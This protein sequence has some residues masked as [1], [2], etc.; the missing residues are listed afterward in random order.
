MPEFRSILVLNQDNIGD[1][2]CTTPLIRRLRDA[3]PA[4]RIDALATSYNAAVLRANPAL[5]QVY[6]IS[7]TK[8][9]TSLSGRVHAV[10][11]KLGILLQLRRNRY[12]MAFLATR[13][14]NG[15]AIQTCRLIGAKQLIGMSQSIRT[16][17]RSGDLTQ[18]E[19]LAGKVNQ[20]VLFADLA[21][22]IGIDGP[23]PPCEVHPEPTVL[24]RARASLNHL[25]NRKSVV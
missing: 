13:S 6:A 3:F 12:D 20:S 7:K 1:L 2:V 4:A 17:Y 23:I 22:L 9:L 21:Q 14:N 8:H 16:G 19:E 10:L 5:D 24:A 15:R 18:G 25:P 11:G